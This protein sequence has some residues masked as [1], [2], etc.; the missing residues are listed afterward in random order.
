MTNY[1]VA[2]CKGMGQSLEY[3]RWTLP[4]ATRE[5][6]RTD[7]PRI[8]AVNEVVAELRTIATKLRNIPNAGEFGWVR[9]ALYT[10]LQAQGDNGAII[11]DL[12]CIICLQNFNTQNRMPNVNTCGHSWCNTCYS[13]PSNNCCPICRAP[14]TAAHTVN[15]SL[16]DI[17]SKFNPSSP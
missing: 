13:H 9:H 15:F 12:T 16:R 11:N 4:R 7:D 3:A 17:S 14:K 10:C 8:P 1:I 2:C 6:P 5:E